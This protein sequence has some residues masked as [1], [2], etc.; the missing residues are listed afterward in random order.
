MPATMEQDI[1]EIPQLAA[2]WAR[3]RGR[4]QQEFGEVEYRT[5]L[6]QMTLAGLDGDEITVH[7]PT[8]F[9]R[10]W[11]RSRYGD[12]INAL[13]RE[14]NPPIR[15]V[16]IRVGPVTEPIR[17]Q[18]DVRP[19]AWPPAADRASAAGAAAVASRNGE[20]RSE[21]NAATGPALHL[22]RLRGRQAERIRLCLRAPR[23]GTAIQ[24]RA[25]I[26]CSC[27]A[28]SGWARRI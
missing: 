26:R 10:D 11:V 16:D 3:V 19:R 23:G 13:W 14:E 21:L 27:T 5:W 22:R 7:L 9:L 1:V 20:P 28:A 15:S 6:R 4:L 8:R 18:P 17:A 24:R 12:R 25:S 2:Q